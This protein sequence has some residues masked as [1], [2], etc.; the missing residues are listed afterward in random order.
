MAPEPMHLDPDDSEDRVSLHRRPWNSLSV[1]ISTKSF[2]LRHVIDDVRDGT[3]DLAPEFKRSL[4]WSSLQTSRLVESVLIGIPLPAFYFNAEPDG[5]L[6]VIDGVQRLHTLRSFADNEFA[7]EGMEYLPELNGRTWTDLDAAYR[8]G[9]SQTSI[10]VHVVDA[11]TPPEIKLELFLRVN[12]GGAP[13]SAQ[14]IRHAMSRERSREVL[15]R[16]TS[17]G[18]FEV[19]ARNHIPRGARMLD[20]ELAL[21]F[22]AFTLDAELETYSVSYTFDD[23][24]FRITRAIDNP[25]AVPEEKLRELEAA[26]ERAMTAAWELFDGHAFSFWPRGDDRRNR[27]NRALFDSWSVALSEHEVG[28]LL[29]RRGSIVRALRDAFSDDPTYVESVRQGTNVKERILK[30]FQVA[31]AILRGG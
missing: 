6:Q 26:F 7:L 12:T 20:R 22:L 5:R 11:A 17:T 4:V 9:F 15:A 19:I 10:M 1:R 24:L 16:M 2:S 28:D 13:L 18:A 8:R 3:I 30:R 31:R 25:L 14:E 29:A 27:I 21:R 23:F